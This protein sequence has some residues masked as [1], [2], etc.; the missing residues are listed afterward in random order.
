MDHTRWWGERGKKLDSFPAKRV[1]T[2]Y[3]RR[4]CEL[5]VV[6]TY[7]LYIMMCCRCAVGGFSF[8]FSLLKW[9]QM[10]FSERIFFL[11]FFLL[12]KWRHLEEEHDRIPMRLRT[13]ERRREKKKKR[14]SKYGVLWRYALP[15]LLTL[16]ATGRV[17]SAAPVCVRGTTVVIAGRLERCRRSALIISFLLLLPKEGPEPFPS[18]RHNDNHTHT[19]IHSAPYQ[20]PPAYLVVL[21]GQ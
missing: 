18:G 14:K 11:S 10:I 17:G 2:E 16:E 4:Y 9:S 21:L 20:R 7:V 6:C 3:M 19:H 1:S 13:K 8:S 12:F 15:T 5:Y